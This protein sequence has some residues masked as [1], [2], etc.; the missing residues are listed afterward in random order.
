M[1][2]GLDK[3][4]K[5]KKT[6]LEVIETKRSWLKFVSTDK[7]FFSRNFYRKSSPYDAVV[8]AKYHFWKDYG[9]FDEQFNPK[10]L[11]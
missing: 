11:G 1:K 6:I 4:P 10:N 8:A 5:L 2:I 3:L 7:R 9:R